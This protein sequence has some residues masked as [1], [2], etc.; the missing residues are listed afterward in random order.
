[1]LANFDR[2]STSALLS[3][4]LFISSAVFC[5]IHWRNRRI[6][7]LQ[8]SPGEIIFPCFEIFILPV[9]FSISSFVTNPWRRMMISLLK[10]LLLLILIR[11]NIFPVENEVYLSVKLFHYFFH[12]CG[13]IFPD[14]FAEG[15]ETGTP[16]NLITLRNISWD[17]ILS[18]TV[19]PRCN[20]VRN[21]S[22][23]LTT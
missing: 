13:E 15:A 21:N 6:M 14:L 3:E 19:I 17:G 10:N 9:T 2:S 12:C 22:F 5:Y 11:P 1:M 4:I 23:F 16:D 7:Y 20:N 18:P 8:K